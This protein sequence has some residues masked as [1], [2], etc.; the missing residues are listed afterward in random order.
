MW[1]SKAGWASAACCASTLRAP[2][3]FAEPDLGRELAAIRSA[4]EAQSRAVVQVLAEGADS[5][6]F[7]VKNARASVITFSGTYR[8][9]E[10]KV[11][12]GH[13]NPPPGSEP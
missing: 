3:F 10:Y 11:L 2:T 1:W 4:I 12:P 6:R 13:V 8:A 7:S 9:T 5:F